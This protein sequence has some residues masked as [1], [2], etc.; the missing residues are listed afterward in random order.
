MS[1]QLNWSHYQLNE[2]LADTEE[3]Q[4]KVAHLHICCNQQTKK[5]WMCQSHA[6]ELDTK[7]SS[8]KKINLSEKEIIMLNYFYKERP[9]GII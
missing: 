3:V 1:V 7:I 4:K 6:E 9:F 5:G 8:S 2:Q